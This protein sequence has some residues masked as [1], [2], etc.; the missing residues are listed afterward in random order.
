MGPIKSSCFREC[1]SSFIITRSIFE[2]LAKGREIAYYNPDFG[3][4]GYAKECV[5]C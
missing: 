4:G 1:F 3:Y 2:E 5:F